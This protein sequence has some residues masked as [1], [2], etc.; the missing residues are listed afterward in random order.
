MFGVGVRMGVEVVDVPVA[1]VDVGSGEKGVAVISC[2]GG[3]VG[4]ELVTS[5]VG[6]GEEQA[7]NNTLVSASRVKRIFIENPL[8]G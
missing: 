8:I 4:A 2:G 5:G 7:P 3:R 1:P 6:V